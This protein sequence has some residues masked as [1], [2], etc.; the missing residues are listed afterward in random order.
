[1]TGGMIEPP[2]EAAAS[3]PPANTREKPRFII[4]GMV[5]TPVESTLT[6]GPPEIVPNIAEDTMAAWAGPPRRRRVQRKASLISDRPPA[7]APNSDP[8]IR[9]GKISLSVISMKRPSRPDALLVRISWTRGR[10][11]ASDRGSPPS[12][13]TRY[14]SM[15]WAP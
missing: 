14:L 12:L 3:M 10:P 9:Y 2:D 13:V 11:S 6:I 7:E 5:S 1:M 8:R 15:S 4:I